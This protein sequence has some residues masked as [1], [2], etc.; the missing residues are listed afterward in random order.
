MALLE[1][2]HLFMIVKSEFRSMM[3]KHVAGIVNMALN[4]KD[5]Q[6]FETVYN[7]VGVLC[8]FWM[9]ESVSSIEYFFK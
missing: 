6:I 3:G 8:R 5:E 9:V 2:T 4:Y 7:L 1:K